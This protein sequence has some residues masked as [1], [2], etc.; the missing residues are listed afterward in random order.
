MVQLIVQIGTAKITPSTQKGS[1]M[2]RNPKYY[3]VR[4]TSEIIAGSDFFEEINPADPYKLNLTAPMDEKEEITVEKFETLIEALR[5]T[6]DVI[7][8][9]EEPTDGWVEIMV[10]Y[11]D[12]ESPETYYSFFQYNP[13]IGL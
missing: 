6:A 8:E 11:Y 4:Y 9:L 5:R 3:Y 7:E 2:E 1:K 10:Y 13:E 12:E